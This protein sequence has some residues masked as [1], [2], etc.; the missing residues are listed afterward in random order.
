MPQATSVVYVLMLYILTL[1][2]PYKSSM[3]FIMSISSFLLLLK[4]F[5]STVASFLYWV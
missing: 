1:F 4:A 3:Y 2:H 5:C